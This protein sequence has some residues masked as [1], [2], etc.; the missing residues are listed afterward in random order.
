MVGG[1]DDDGE[2]SRAQR[3]A[4]HRMWL[5]MRVYCD[6]DGTITQQDSTDMV[7]EALA[8]PPWRALQADWEA[9]RLSGAACMQGQVELIRGAATDLD[10]VLDGVMLDT[11][12]IAFVDWCEAQ[13]VP[14]GVVSDGVDYFIAR[15]LARHGLQ[16]LPVL[17]NHLVG[18]ADAWRLEHP[19]KPVDCASGAGV[20]KCAAAA[21][22]SVDDTVIFV[23]DGRSDFCVSGRADILFAKGALAA[24]AGAAAKPYLP[25]DTFHDVRRTLAVLV[26]D[27]PSMLA[28]AETS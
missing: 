19:D 5:V 15:I 18:A 23:G 25:F 16:R 20:C 14:V 12:F 13:G 28:T 22:A 8:D 1:V 21:R 4:L 17:A 24:H 2:A 10:A 27:R 9:G 7:L 26:G 11:G 3:R 6:F